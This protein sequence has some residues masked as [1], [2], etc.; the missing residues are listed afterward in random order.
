M[1]VVSL[2]D[3][4]VRFR[5]LGGGPQC[6]ID[7]VNAHLSGPGGGRRAAHATMIQP[8]EEY[9]DD[10]QAVGEVPR[11]QRRPTMKTIWITSLAWNNI[12]IERLLI[13]RAGHSL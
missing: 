1:A 4:N 8:L 9:G 10:V 7:A 2:V 6:E 12:T 5:V 11:H 13:L 3:C